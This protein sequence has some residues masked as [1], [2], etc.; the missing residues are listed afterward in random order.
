MNIK[1]ALHLAKLNIPVSGI[2]SKQLRPESS[3]QYFQINCKQAALT[4][5]L[6]LHSATKSPDSQAL[7]K[8]FLAAIGEAQ[9]L[10]ERPSFPNLILIQQSQVKSENGSHFQSNKGKDLYLPHP[11]EMLENSHLKKQAW[12]AYLTW[13]KQF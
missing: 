3:W 6:S 4:F 10:A 8:R 2:V 11:D 1:Q 7:F 12:N 5:G 9:P 13:L